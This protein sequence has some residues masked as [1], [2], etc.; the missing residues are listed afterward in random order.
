ME[1]QI[2]PTGEYAAFANV[3]LDGVGTVRIVATAPGAVAAKALAHAQA[4][5][6]KHLG[7][8]PSVLPPPPMPVPSGATPPPPIPLPI[9][10][11]FTPPTLRPAWLSPPPPPPP[12][13]PPVAEP[14]PPRGGV[15]AATR[16][17]IHQAVAAQPVALETARAVRRFVPL[18]RR[19]TSATT[20]TYNR[21]GVDRRRR[22]RRFA[23]P[24]PLPTA[25]SAAAAATAMVPMAQL[26]ERAAM[27]LET[28]RQDPDAEARL[29]EAVARARRDGRL[30]RV[31]QSVRTAERR[32]GPEGVAALRRLAG[33]A[34][35]WGRADEGDPEAQAQLQQVASTMALTEGEPDPSTAQAAGFLSVADLELV[36]SGSDDAGAR[37]TDY[38]GGE[39]VVAGAAAWDD[40]YS[41]DEDDEQS[42]LEYMQALQGM[43][44][45]YRRAR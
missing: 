39:D 10:M 33:A 21:Q 6:S 27:L 30:M 23:E 44:A 35:L 2:L 8:M 15:M 41:D 31:L 12:P 18:L 24:E 11:P 38:D 17:A 40:E 29:A 20:T 22:R 42:H 25:R 14:L 45:G 37:L 26:F 3:H 13:P 16:A 1:P 4:F 7:R 19:T 9:P 32:D 36:Q 43:R 34:A 5:L 28:A